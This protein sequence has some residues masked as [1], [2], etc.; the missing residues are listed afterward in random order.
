[1]VKYPVRQRAIIAAVREARIAAG[2]SQRALSRLLKEDHS[3]INNIELL[4]RDL[5]ISEFIEI[6]KV[7]K[8]DPIELLRKAL[9]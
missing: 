7:L 6:A 5:S 3:L 2:L 9:R 1:M 4:R 8:L